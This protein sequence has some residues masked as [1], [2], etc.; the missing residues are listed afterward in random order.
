MKSGIIRRVDQLGRIVLP[1]E[2]R[3]S[4]KLREGTQLE[5]SL[6]GDKIILTKCDI[7]ADLKLI[8]EAVLDSL[9]DKYAHFLIC[10]NDTVVATTKRLK[11]YLGEALDYNQSNIPFKSYNAK[12]T[13]F[14]FDSR[15][16]NRYICSILKEGDRLGFVVYCSTETIS[17]YEQVL[18]NFVCDIISRQV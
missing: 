13:D 15:Y 6:E 4:M 1:M 9:P 8:G 7:G 2:L 18:A 14:A 5:F 12:G 3:K 10:D 16:S 11:N 17:E